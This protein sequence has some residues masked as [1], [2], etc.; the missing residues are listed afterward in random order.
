MF[1][2]LPLRRLESQ[3]LLTGERREENNR[4]KRFYRLSREGK[5]ML[6]AVRMYLPKRTASIQATRLSAGFRETFCSRSR[7]TAGKTRPPSQA[8]LSSVWS[9]G[10]GRSPRRQRRPCLLRVARE[11]IIIPRRHPIWQIPFRAVLLPGT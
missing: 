2:S 11:M 7:S 6:D 5:V 10:P 1:R 3:G 4:R 8:G 9:T